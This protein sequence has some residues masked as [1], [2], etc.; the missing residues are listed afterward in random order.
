MKQNL[1]LLIGVGEE[2]PSQS[3]QL[4]HRRQHS[5]LLVGKKIKHCFQ[6]RDELV[7]YN[8]TILSMNPETTEFEVEYE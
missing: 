7:W 4:S 6:V 3:K 1:L 8:G 5:E 2:S